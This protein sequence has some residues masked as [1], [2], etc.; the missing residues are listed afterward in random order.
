MYKLLTPLGKGLLKK[1]ESK[2]MKQP[3]TKQKNK[4]LQV[5]EQVVI[6]IIIQ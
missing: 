5:I 6:M 2:L 3:N 4:N 1:I